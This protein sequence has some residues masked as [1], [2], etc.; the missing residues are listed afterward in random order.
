MPVATI[1]CINVY[2][3]HEFFSHR[4]TTDDI[5]RNPPPAPV[6]EI[7]E[8]V[9]LVE[10]VFVDIPVDEPQHQLPHDI[11]NNTTVNNILGN[12]LYSFTTPIYVLYG[13][14]VGLFVFIANK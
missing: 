12:I 13:L 7:V 4:S 6:Y 9:D 3:C 14:L 8:I 2:L 11:K 5:D 10:P 1:L